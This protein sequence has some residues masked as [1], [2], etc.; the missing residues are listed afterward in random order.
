MSAPRPHPDSVAPDSDANAPRS[1]A[2]VWSSSERFLAEAARMLAQS[3]DYAAT[4]RCVVDLA[5]PAF[6]DWCLVDLLT[7]D[8]MSFDRVAVG[9]HLAGGDAVARALKQRYPLRQE[10]QSRVERALLEGRS[11]LSRDMDEAAVRAVARDEAHLEALLTM[12]VRSAVVAPMVARGRAIGVLSLLVCARNFDQRDLWFG[13]QLAHSAAAAIDNARLYEAER[14]AR[15]QITQLQ[16]VTAALSRASTAEEVAADCCRIGSEAVG[17]HSAALWLAQADGSLRLAGA[18]GSSPEFLQRFQVIPAG[19]RGLPAMAVLASG[20]PLWVE[21]AADYQ[22]AAPEF[23]AVAAS[24]DRLVAYGAVP[25]SLDGRVNGVLVF[26]HALGHHYDSAERA[27]FSALAQHCSQ[28]LDRARLLDT[29]R[30]L[31]E[32]ERRASARVRLLAQV[33]ETLSSSLDLDETLRKIAKL[34]V[35]TL[36]DWCVIDL[37]EGDVI[38]RVATENPDPRKVERAL[39][40]AARS[41]VRVGDGSAIARVIAMGKSHFHPR[42]AHEVLASAA[43][44]EEQLRY[45]QSEGIV[46]SIV[47]PLFARGACVGALSLTTS[48]SGRVYDE[49][50]LTFAE[51]L[52]RRAGMSIS[53]ARLHRELEEAHARM[54]RLFAQAP[55]A[56]AIFRGPEHRIEYANP[57][58]L[59]VTSRGEDVIGRLHGEV[60]PE[61][62]STGHAVLDQAFHSGEPCT[63]PEVRVPLDRGQGP[64]EAYFHVSVVPLRDDRGAPDRLMSVSFDVTDRV[65]ARRALDAERSKLKTVF[66]QAPFPLGVFEGPEHRIV[67]ANS[68]WEALVQR[69]LTPG[70]RLEDVVPELRAQN[71]LG[72]HD[73]AFAGETVV[74][75]DVPLDLMVDGQVH[76]HFFHVVMQPL[77]NESGGI[78][79]HV[80]MA[81]DV[82]EQVLTR[83]DLETARR[84]A[85]AASRAKDDFLAMLGHELRNPLAPIVTALKLMELQDPDGSERE[86]RVISRQVQH[87]TRLVDDLLDVSR[88]ARGKIELRKE[89]TEVAHFVARAVE[90]ASPL[91]E[92]RHQHVR[93]AVPE[94]GLWVDA[95]SGRMAQALSNLLTNAAKYSDVGGHIAIS[96]SRSKNEIVIT[97]SDDGMGIPAEMLGEI[98]EL[99]VQERQ[100]SDRARGGLGLGLAIVKSVVT[101]HGGSVSAASEGP[102]KGSVFSIRLPAI[103]V[104]DQERAQRATPERSLRKPQRVLRILVVDDNEDAADLLALALSTAGHQTR[105]A[106]DGPSAL[107]ALED[108][109]PDAAVLDIGLPAMDGYDLARRIREK[110][111]RAHLIALTGYGQKSDLER[112]SAAGFAVH[113]VKPVDVDVVLRVVEQASTE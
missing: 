7:E 19:T 21:T 83:L 45:L 10:P 44:D 98:F 108:F 90:T 29:E 38:R 14:R 105:K 73:R 18:W 78:D 8:G 54:L 43:R 94:R 57:T 66:E 47:V 86:R 13:E 2:V 35:P 75:N 88:I 36:A 41:E 31:L 99:F 92:Q 48:D 67:L 4:V 25:I 101:M 40:R 82:T 74:G 20:E 52:A 81:I 59:A 27:F 103:D 77:R 15:V 49:G 72:L 84:D 42:L 46:S 100:A 5:V 109:D 91:F 62:R 51:E 56:I 58:Y 28:A 87:L 107:H 89:P 76:S 68:K 11:F 102:G 104:T 55:M 16:A 50:D 32:S 6:A 9:H 22:R 23:Y 60:F 79:G 113:L 1:D 112:S 80:T 110:K 97:V 34:V 95:D 17:A 53:N 70:A 106:F 37:V 93:V 3:L 96:A 71:I 65:L 39:E 12:R 30:R 69:T 111:P 24:A 26:A 64:Q 33:S 63:F 61:A 85:E